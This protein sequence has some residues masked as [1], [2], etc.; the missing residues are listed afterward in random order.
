MGGILH[1]C[2][3]E[4]CM[5]PLSIDLTVQGF[6]AHAKAKRLNKG[7]ASLGSDTHDKLKFEYLSDGSSA[8]HN[9]G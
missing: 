4:V 7:I 8:L 9:R 3:A 6:V 1:I 2:P 5:M